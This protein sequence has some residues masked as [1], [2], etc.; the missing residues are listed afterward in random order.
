[1]DNDGQI[2]QLSFLDKND[3]R[4][5]DITYLDYRSYGESR[6]PVTL[7]IQDAAGRKI[8]LS[9]TTFIPNPPI[10]ESVFRLT[11]SGS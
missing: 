9:L 4:L 11:E 6:I 1:L 7:L 2:Q 10:K 3:T 5:Y 8:H